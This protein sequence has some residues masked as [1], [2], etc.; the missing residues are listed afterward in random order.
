MYT[1]FK[2]GNL[3]LNLITESN[4]TASFVIVKKYRFEPEW[5]AKQNTNAMR[6]TNRYVTANFIVYKLVIRMR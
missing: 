5:N 3:N 2:V 1:N 4:S 6:L